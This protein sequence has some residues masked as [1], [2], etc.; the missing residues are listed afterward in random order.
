M[1]QQEFPPAKRKYYK[2]DDEAAI[3]LGKKKI[4]L[5]FDDSTMIC[6]LAGVYEGKGLAVMPLVFSEEMLA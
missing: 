3:A 4:D 2:S 6:Y 1:V 5:F